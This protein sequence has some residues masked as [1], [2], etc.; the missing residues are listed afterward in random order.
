MRIRSRSYES[1]KGGSWSGL[2]RKFTGELN[3]EGK[4]NRGRAR[5]MFHAEEAVCL[6]REAG[7]FQELKNCRSGWSSEN[8][9]RAVVWTVAAR[10]DREEGIKA[11]GALLSI[12]SVERSTVLCRGLMWSDLCFETLH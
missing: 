7:M 12:F 4:W 2:E 1:I 6:K 9:E 5:R 3:S 10:Q 8:E 11:L